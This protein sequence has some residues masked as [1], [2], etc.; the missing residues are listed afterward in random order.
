MHSGRRWKS[1]DQIVELGLAIMDGHDPMAEVLKCVA[2][3]AELLILG[4]MLAETERPEAHIFRSRAI[5][6]H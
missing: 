6:V 5:L 1:R 4:K 2:A 3:D